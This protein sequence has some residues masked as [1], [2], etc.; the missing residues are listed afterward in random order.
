MKK[1]LVTLFG[2]LPLLVAVATISAAGQS[3]ATTKP[4]TPKTAEQGAPAT[5]K[6]P[7]QA[8]KAAELVDIN[9]ATREQLQALPG[10]GDAY[11]QKIIDGRPYKAK[12]EL[13]TKNVVPAATYSKISKL[14]IAKQPAKA[15]PKK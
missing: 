13:K 1:P 11:A 4:A 12:T 2:I 14:I 15:A 9:T 6:P 10:I 3:A 5:T 8:T 7:E